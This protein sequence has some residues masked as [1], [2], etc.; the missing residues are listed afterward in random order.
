MTELPADLLRDPGEEVA[1]RQD[2]VQ[3]ALGRRPADRILRVDRLFDAATATWIADAEI[4][5]RG[6]RIAHVGPRGSFAGTAAEIVERPG[7]AA[8]PGFGEAHKHIESSHLTPEHEAAL[9]IPRGCTW[10]CEASHEFSNVNGAR[11]L[12]FWLMARAAGSPM[13]CFPLPG[14]AVPPTAWEVSG[15]HFTGADQARFMAHPMVAGLDEVMDWPGLTDPAN[16]A[17][18]RLWGMIGATLAARGVVEGHGAGL[19][20]LPA[21]NAFAAAG[22]ASDHEAWTAG[23]AWDKLRRGLFLQIRIHSLPEIVA[24]L[25]DRGLTDWSQVAFVTDD[26]PAHETLR[27]GATDHNLRQAIAAGLPPETAFQCVTVNPA[28][29]MRLLPWVGLAAPGRYADLVLLSDP[30]RV[31]IAEVWA[32][33]RPVSEGGRYTG[34][35]P[36]IDWPDW[37]ADTVR[38]PRDLTAEDFAIPAPP[39]R[40]TVS[41]AVLR[42]FHWADDFLTETLEVEDGLA[43]RDPARAITKFAVVDRHTGAGGVA[44]MFWRG[45][46]PATPGTAVACSVAHDSHNIWVVGSCDAAMAAAVNRLRANRGGWV[47]V[48]G[49]RVLAEV[50]FEIGGLMTAR[51]AVA[52]AADMA[53]LLA[54]ADS[55]DWLWEPTFSPRWPKGFPHR[56]QFATLTCAPWRWVLV[57]PTAA[58]PQG[59]VNVATG[60]THPVV[61]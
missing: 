13:K 7:L 33:G 40:G 20:D 53:R 28:R 22:L 4:A 18:G 10:V 37:A 59:L 35:L 30:A 55:I 44:R 60:A 15:G 21:I 43:C 27:I 32:D 39:G 47:L 51:P 48:S 57:A 8:V 2:L 31:A 12:D 1:I 54:A 14:S 41:A 19:R 24:G 6:R 17:H 25:L 9:V 56:L 52:L 38:L 5:I 36:A 45:C 58:A 16:P 23:E 50:R 49:G 3:V 26:R 42:P 34:L 29:H 11:N 46:G 61:W